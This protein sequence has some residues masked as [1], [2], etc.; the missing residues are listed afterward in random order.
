[1]ISS[2]GADTDA[3]TVLERILYLSCRMAET[4]DL[5]PL[6]V[7]AVDVALE[8]FHAEQGYLILR[9]PDGSLEFPVRRRSDGQ[10]LEQPEISYKVLARV[11]NE[12]KPVATA[13]AL[14]E[15]ELKSTSVMDLQLRSLM[16]VPLIAHQEIIGALY[17]DNRWQKGMFNTT[18]L[19]FLQL[20]ANQVAVSIENARL[21][22]ELEA[23]VQARTVELQQTN[24]HLRNEIIERQRAEQQLVAMQMERERGKVLTE[25]IQDASHQFYTPLSVINTSLYLLAQQ[26]DKAPRHRANIDTAAR[27]IHELVQSLLVMLKLNVGRGD[28]T[29]PVNLAQVTDQ[30]LTR[31]ASQRTTK[32]LALQTDLQRNTAIRHGNL[33]QIQQIIYQIVLNAIQYTPDGGSIGVRVYDEGGA[34]VVEVADTGSGIEEVEIPLIFKRFY[35]GDKVGTTRGLGLGLSIAEKAAQN[36]NGRIEVSSQPGHGSVFRLILPVA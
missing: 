5:G 10:T 2:F 30:V 28:S 15:P 6:L 24:D 31:L 22:D 36:H 7:Y 8:L 27:A 34:A 33:E 35:R 23:R 25:F 12:G 14:G 3:D 18:D 32:N 26:P 1:M 11:L 16:C 21:V 9:R 19:N 4:R 29:G 17:L 13:N 20:F